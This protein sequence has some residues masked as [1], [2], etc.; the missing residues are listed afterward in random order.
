[1]FKLRRLLARRRLRLGR[2]LTIAALVIAVTT[3]CSVDQD[4]KKRQFVAAGDSFASQKEFKE[5]LVEYRNAVQ[6]DPMFGEA[7]LKLAG[8]YEQV[9]DGASALNEYVRAADLLPNDVA[10][11]LKAGA[12]L[13]AS[14][15]VDDALARADAALKLQPDNVEAHILRGNA[16]GGLNNFDQAIKEIE[17]ALRLDPASGATYTQLGLVESARGRHA[18]AE[19]AFRR[20]ITLEP[21]RIGA[22]LALANFYWAAGRFG[23][24]GETLEST[25]QMAPNDEETNH[26]LAIFSLATGRIREAEKY[27]KQLVSINGA[28]AAQFTLADYYIATHRSSEAIAILAPITSGPRPPAQARQRLARAYMGADMPD[29]AQA[30][31]NE[32]LVETP[33]D[34]EAQLLKGQLAL[35]ENKPDEAITAVKAAVA[36]APASAEAQF[37]LGRVYAARGDYAGAENAFREVLKINPAAAAAQT[38]LS[39]LQL[40]A[41]AASAS[42][43]N[44]E[45]AVKNQP[46]RLDTR[47]ALVRSLLAAKQLDRAQRELQPL[48]TTHAHVPAVLVQSAVLAASRNDMAGARATFEK[49]LV[50]DPNSLE[51]FG[52]V[53]AL[54]LNAKN[55]GAARDRVTRKLESGP[56]TA[57]LLLLAARTYGSANDLASAERVLRQAIQMDATLLPAYSMLGQIYLQQGKLD[58][59]RQEFDNLAQKQSNPVGAL[60]MAGMILQAQNNSPQARARYERAVTLD[61]RAAVA[62]NNLAWMYAESGEKLDDALRL[63]R[64][65]AEALPESADILDTLGWV[66]YKNNLADVA[67]GPLVRSVEKE[68]KNADYR[69]HL[70]LVYIKA[71]DTERG[72][73]TLTA[74]LDMAPEAVWAPEA[75]RAISGIGQKR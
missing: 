16:L 4:T 34:A 60:T 43:M 18:E 27:L 68:P 5:A 15:R 41:G 11:Q 50:A 67:I 63:A 44:A 17:E 22:R 8:A 37:V 29:K 55:Y 70:G 49:A 39:I 48:L 36:A 51:A 65:A 14:R 53:L 72:R 6:I 56:V 1:M 75:K 59:A 45:A 47:L 35:Q 66:Y 33:G 19:A 52:G 10:L 73:E 31:I 20:A 58:Q 64:N 71:G 54:D 12:Y 23:E 74:A 25:L 24:A 30:V 57:P 2:A 13:I 32:L 42:L 40:S 38:E 3:A 7:R 69:F 62:A 21:S 9:G 46:D 61:P 28:P 26:A